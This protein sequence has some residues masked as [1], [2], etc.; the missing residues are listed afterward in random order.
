MEEF[1]NMLKMWDEERYTQEFPES[2]QK[3]GFPPPALQKNYPNKVKLIDLIPPEEITIGN[4]SLRQVI[5]K[6]ESHRKFSDEPLT[7][8]ELSF[9]LWCTQ[10]VKKVARNRIKRTTPSAGARHPFE[11]YLI[12]NRVEG[13]EQGL[14][15]FLSIDHKLSF[16]Q[17]LEAVDVL[18]EQLVYK[19]YSFVGKGAVVFCWVVIPY[20]M[21]WRHSVF[22]SKFIALEAGHICQNLYLACEAIN[23][24]TCA[25]GYYNQDRVDK[26]LD[27]DGKDEFTIYIAPVGK[28]TPVK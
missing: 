13:L 15:R 21:E 16:L 19:Q 26:F 7:L 1:R 9:L 4:M 14:Y 17:P 20:R 5:T 28:I 23:A 12:I 8:E 3:K 27:I 18:I 24:G 2:D 25:I 10:G 22:S 6:R 11:T